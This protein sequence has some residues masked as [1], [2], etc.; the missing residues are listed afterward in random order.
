MKRTHFTLIFL[1]IAFASCKKDDK[2]EETKILVSNCIVSLSPPFG[3]V[4]RG[5]NFF[6][7]DRQEKGHKLIVM[8]GDK[9]RSTTYINAAGLE[10]A[11]ENIRYEYCSPKDTSTYIIKCQ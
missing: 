5:S 11:I 9:V 10:S 7:F 1:L 4:S 2:P 3:Y 8:T 6:D